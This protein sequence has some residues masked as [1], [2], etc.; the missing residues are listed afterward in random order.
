M[1][2]ISSA[3]NYLKT[4][5]NQNYELIWAKTWDDT[6]KGIEWIADLP[7]VSPGRWAV[8]YNYLYVMTRILNEKEPK[9]ILDIGLGISSTLISQYFIGKSISDGLHDVIEQDK[10]WADF[11]S[12]KHELPDSTKIHISELSE[13]VYKNSKYFSYSDIS[14]IV[15][16]KKYDVISI[17]GPWGGE[18]Y[19]R[20]DVLEFIPEILSDSFVIV[21]DDT[22]RK[23]EQSTV[24][25]IKKI[26]E[27]NG[28]KYCEGIYFGMTYCTV[29]TSADNSF[30]CS[31]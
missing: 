9:S 17:D 23:G 28:I 5:R 18:K 20:R 29:I 16:G 8:G 4:I 24:K 7:G 2:I 19:S 1:G 31:M 30:L 27:E 22:N 13:K 11:Y 21:M 10:V 12:S 3:K 14:S 26:L 6:K 25:A 15:K